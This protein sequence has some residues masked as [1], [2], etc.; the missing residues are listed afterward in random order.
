MKWWD[1]IVEVHGEAPYLNVTVICS[2]LG[3]INPDIHEI[4]EELFPPGEGKEKPKMQI[5]PVCDVC[6]EKF[7][8]GV[9]WHYRGKNYCDECAPP[10]MHET[11]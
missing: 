11:G 9:G 1:I 7:E 6:G 5:F 10:E 8:E 2:R 4:G 3:E